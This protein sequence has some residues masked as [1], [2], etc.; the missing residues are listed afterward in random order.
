MSAAII[1][2]MLGCSC[3]SAAGLF[4]TCTDGKLNLSN[5]SANTCFS[6]LSSNTTPSDPEVVD[7]GI[8]C[9]FITVEQT[10]S[11]AITLSDIEVYDM[12]GA[13]LVVHTAPAEGSTSPRQSIVEGATT[14][15]GLANFIDDEGTDTATL[16]TVPAV[17]ADATEKAKVVVDLGGLKKVHKVVLTNTATTADQSKICGS[18][19]VFSGNEVDATGAVSKKTIEETPTIKFVASSYTYAITSDLDAWK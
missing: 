13:S 10:T 3:S 15:N 5:L 18:K 2:A 11:N 4:Y 14:E 12:A 9:Q 19:L 7:L 17:A 6:F 1:M 8:N 16:G